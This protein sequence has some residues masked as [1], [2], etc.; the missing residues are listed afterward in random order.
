MGSAGRRAKRTAVTGGVVRPKKVVLLIDSNE[1]RQ[2]LTRLVLDCHGYRVISAAS[3]ED[4]KKFRGEVHCVVGFWP[5]RTLPAAS[6][7]RRNFAKLVVVAEHMSG[8]PDGE[9]ADHWL[10][11]GGC[12]PTLI[13]EAVKLACA[14]KRGPHSAESIAAAAAAAEMVAA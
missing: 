9:F 4:A 11:K 2:S 6:V 14:R 8:I 10:I 3:A 1:V 7:A 5:V 13:I 12:S